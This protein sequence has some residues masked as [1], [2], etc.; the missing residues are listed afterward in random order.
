M[1]ERKNYQELIFSIIKTPGECI[2][3]TLIIQILSSLYFYVFISFWQLHV[4]ILIDVLLSLREEPNELK[5]FN[6]FK[7]SYQSR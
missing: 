5:S 6:G 4:K 1:I 2:T 3:R 7:Q